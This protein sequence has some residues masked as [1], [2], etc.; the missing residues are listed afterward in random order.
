MSDNGSHFF[1]QLYLSNK[2]LHFWIHE[3]RDGLEIP[4]KPPE[5]KPR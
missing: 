4:R 5:R 3:I 2:Q 1:T